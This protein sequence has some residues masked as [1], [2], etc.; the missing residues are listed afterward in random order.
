MAVNAVRELELEDARAWF[1]ALPRELRATTLSPDF[2]EADTRRAPGLRRMHVGFE[3]GGQRWLHGFHLWEVPGFGFAAQSAYGYGGPLATSDDPSFI[4]AAWEAYRTWAAQRQVLAEFCRFHPEPAQQRFFGGDTR[5]N[6]VTV[7]VDLTREPLEGQYNALA[8]RKLRKVAGV[9]VRW[10]RER[11]DWLAF[12]R[13]YRQ[14]MA[15]L[16]AQERHLFGDA[17]FLALAELPAACLCIVG[18]GDW[19]SAG[20]YL[21]Q[22]TAPEPA[23]TG[24]AEYHLGAS[25][26]EGH[27]RGTAY[28][29]QHAAA[30]EARRRGLASLYLGGGITTAPDDSLL[31]YKRAFSRRE[32]P[33]HVANAV[34][35]PDLYGGYVRSRGYDPAGPHPHLLFE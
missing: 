25:S 10:S 31:F 5:L 12:A 13:F 26:A 34:H 15:A 20:A 6:R 28:L 4:T 32:R 27:A 30:T 21:F 16:G 11:A 22:D 35:R 9:P 18:E 1:S 2:I 8:R 19:L 7:S 23:A 33:F 14:A 24:T 17:Y 3:Q 29:L